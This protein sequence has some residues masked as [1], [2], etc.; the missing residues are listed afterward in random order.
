M[1]QVD[2]VDAATPST[3]HAT[4]HAHDGAVGRNVVDDDGASSDLAAVSDRDV[5]QDRR[6]YARPRRNPASV[7]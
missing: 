6:S 1:V 3:D 7:G 5:A 4:G 2:R